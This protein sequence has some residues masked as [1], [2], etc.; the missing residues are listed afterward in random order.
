MLRSLRVSRHWDV[1]RM[2]RELHHAADEPVAAH[3][4]LVR[5]IRSWEG[6]AHKVSERYLLLYRRVF[7]EEWP[8][9][10]T[11]PPDPAAVLER[12]RRVPGDAAIDAI[13]DP[14][15]RAV[16]AGLKQQVE[17]LGK[18]LEDMLGEDSP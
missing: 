17:V 8:V 4:A 7:P 14:A 16:L 11:A 12:A 1:D 10:G 13:G 3:H 5:M 6:G 15:V 2:A 18:M 9:N